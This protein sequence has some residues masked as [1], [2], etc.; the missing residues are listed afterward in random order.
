M[1]RSEGEIVCISVVPGMW[2]QNSREF[3][4]SPC[5]LV[6]VDCTLCFKNQK[7]EMSLGDGTLTKPVGDSLMPILTQ[8]DRL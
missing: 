5:Y 7:V 3:K 1:G 6:I 8:R 2:K 4:A